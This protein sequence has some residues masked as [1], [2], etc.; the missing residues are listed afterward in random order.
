MTSLHIQVSIEALADIERAVTRV[1]LLNNLEFDLD[2]SVLSSVIELTDY[3]GMR[4]PT[5]ARNFFGNTWLAQPGMDKL[6]Y[7]ERVLT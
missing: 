5:R 7:S 6:A 3:P 1:T 2:L 4:I